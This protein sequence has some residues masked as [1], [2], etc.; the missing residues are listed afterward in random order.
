VRARA[1]AQFRDRRETEN[2]LP[3]SGVV[4]ET[5]RCRTVAVEA[6]ASVTVAAVVD[7]DDG[8]SRR[9]ELA[10]A[11]AAGAWRRGHERMVVQ[12]DQLHKGIPET[13]VRPL[14]RGAVILQVL[15]SFDQ[16]SYVC[17]SMI[18]SYMYDMI[19]IIM[20]IV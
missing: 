10:A 18:F 13:V 9:E 15:D 7:S 11:A 12:V 6:A 3:G 2:D 8:R 16:S 1:C 5:V 4:Q 17:R 14:Q 19:I 20:S